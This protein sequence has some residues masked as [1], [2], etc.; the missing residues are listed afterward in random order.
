MAQGASPGTAAI[1]PA[2]P[3]RQ[4]SGLVRSA[5]GFDAFVFALSGISVGIMFE[6]GSFFATGFYPGGN[7][8]VALLISVA[9]ALV[10]AFAYRYWG[11][12]FPRS[13]GDYVFLSRGFH[14]GFALGVNFVYCWILMVSP[15]FAM[16]IM[17]PLLSSFASVLASATGWHFLDS[18]STW[19]G[20]NLGYAVI[21][22]VDLLLAAAIGVFGLKRSIMYMKSLFYVGLGA[23]VI[24]VI[25]LLF[26]HTSTFA[27]HLQAATGHTVAQIE[28]KAKATGFEHG[29]FN[30]LHTFKVTNWYVTSLFFAA[31]LLYIGGEIKNAARN[32]RRAL[33]AA[34]IFSGLATLVWTVVL[35][36]VVPTSLQGALAWNSYSAPTYSTAAVPYPHELMALLWGTSGAGLILTIIAFVGCLAWVT[37]WTPLVLSFAQRGI[38]AWALDG[39]TPRWVGRVNERYHTP[40]PALLIALF[41]GESFMLWFAFDPGTRT[42]ILLVPLFVGIGLSMLVGT[43]FPYVRKDLMEQ[44]IVADKK[45]FGIHRMSILCGA[46]TIIMAFWSWLMWTDH[47]ASGTDRTPIWVTLGIV[48]AIT[49]YYFCLRAYKRREGEDITVTFKRIPIE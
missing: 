1:R 24:L 37:L 17:Q 45:W 49:I 19:F 28:T 35:N 2:P 26:S 7:Q 23:E 41:M 27:H 21:G 33:V 30:L 22:S 11:Q 38:L 43:F 8:V 12:I 36:H 46:G 29:G 16:S 4:K 25:A 44:S 13:G 32:I 39:L 34:V 3:V 10:V 6:W 18:L 48:A 31:L 15:A 5:S 47:I 42:I 14:P 9:A 40:I 20:T